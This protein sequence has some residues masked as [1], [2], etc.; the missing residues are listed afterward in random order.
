ML[1]DADVI[2]LRPHSADLVHAVKRLDADDVAGVMRRVRAELRVDPGWALAVVLADE[3][4][5][6]QGALA[7]VNEEASQYATAYLDQKRRV[8]ELREIL[9]MRA[10]DV[11]AKSNRKAA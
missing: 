9:G 1:S 4:L 8:G 5:R 2:R 6:L 3:V 11:A 7:R 10:A